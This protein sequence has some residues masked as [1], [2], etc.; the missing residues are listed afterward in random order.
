ILFSE[1]NKKHNIPEYL[2]QIV[3]EALNIIPKKALQIFTDGNKN[4]DNLS[5]NSIVVKNTIYQLSNKI[6]NS[7][8]CSAFRWELFAIEDDLKAAATCTLNQDFW[9]LTN[10]RSSIQH[11][12]NWFCICNKVPI[13]ILLFYHDVHL[14]WIPSH[15]GISGNKMAN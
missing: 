4:E 1:T 11:L 13:S 15:I 2:R 9:I 6:S 3:L 12:R 10:N 14:Q 7:N 8:H 5:G